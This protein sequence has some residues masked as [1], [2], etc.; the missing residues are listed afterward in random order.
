MRSHDLVAKLRKWQEGVP[1][2]LHS[3]IE[4]ERVEGIEPSNRL[5]ESRILPL[6]YTRKKRRA[7]AKHDGGSGQALVLAVGRLA[8]AARRELGNYAQGPCS[9]LYWKIHY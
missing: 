2:L 1:V 7:P 6:N 3:L 9:S 8:S 5:W 4:M